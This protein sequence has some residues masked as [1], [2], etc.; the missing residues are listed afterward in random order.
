LWISGAATSVGALVSWLLPL[1][2][3]VPLPSDDRCVERAA[4]ET[5]VARSAAEEREAFWF[6][7]VGSLAVNLGAAAAIAETVSWQ[8]GARSFAIGYSIALLQ[9]YTM[10]RTM[11]RRSR[12][13]SLT[14][15]A[16]PGHELGVIVGGRF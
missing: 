16:F 12:Q 1:D 4:L 11:W 14:V 2:I 6:Q 7:H 13:P 8:A 15:Q 5:A 3:S 10:P 9:T